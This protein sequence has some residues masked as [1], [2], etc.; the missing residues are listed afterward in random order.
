M[1]GFSVSASESK[2]G[3]FFFQTH[4]LHG[5]SAIVR[6]EKSIIG[7]ADNSRTLTAASADQNAMRL[8]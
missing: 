4:H 1:S 7:E 8:R 3:G 6:G 2:G 5:R